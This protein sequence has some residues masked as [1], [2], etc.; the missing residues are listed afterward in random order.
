MKNINNTTF[1]KALPFFIIAV[2]FACAR[3]SAPGGGPRDEAPPI[4]LK[5]SPINYSTN[6]NG[7]YWI[8]SQNNL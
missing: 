2:S 4:A 5:S 8:F 7:N 3:M 6:F 1:I